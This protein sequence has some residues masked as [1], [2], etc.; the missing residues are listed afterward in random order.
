MWAPSPS[1]VDLKL[2]ATD[3]VLIWVGATR[4]FPRMKIQYTLQEIENTQPIQPNVKLL[5]DYMFE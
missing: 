1:L 3:V 2:C 5:G 4:E